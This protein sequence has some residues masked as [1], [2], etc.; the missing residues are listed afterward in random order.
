MKI[1][2]VMESADFGPAYEGET[3][4]TVTLRVPKDIRVGPGIHTIEFKEIGKPA[5]ATAK[6]EQQYANRREAANS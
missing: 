2:A 5:W 4:V 1:D 6:D 3:F